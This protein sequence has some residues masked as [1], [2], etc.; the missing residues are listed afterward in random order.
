M[1]EGS[2]N[3][4]RQ[5]TLAK[6]ST[7]DELNDY[8]KVTNPGV[9]AVLIAV[10]LLLVG[11]LVWACVGTLKTKADGRATVTGG[12]AAIVVSDAYTL[13]SGMPATVGTAECTIQDTT[14]G[15]S[16]TTV[17]L[18]PVEI[19]DGTYDAT[20]VVDETH[21]IDFLLKSN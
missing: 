15:A 12:M 1:A 14:L 5:K 16:G 18:A 17:G 20:V 3:P 2:T 11:T 10:I 7:P 21:A 6:L 19:A 8:L 4:Y 13:E 9:W